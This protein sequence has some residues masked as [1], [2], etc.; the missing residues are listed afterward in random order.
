MRLVV[1]KAPVQTYSL[2]GGHGVRVD[3]LSLDEVAALFGKLG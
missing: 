2:V 3:G 1:V